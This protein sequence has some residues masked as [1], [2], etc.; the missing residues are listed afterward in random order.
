MIILYGKM[1]LFFNTL[2]IN[3]HMIMEVKHFTLMS[4]HASV[5][6]QNF[7]M[8]KFSNKMPNMASFHPL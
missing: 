7:M 1:L 8:V 2:T 5:H 6:K 3:L 4:G